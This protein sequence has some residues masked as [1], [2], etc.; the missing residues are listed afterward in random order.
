MFEKFFGFIL[1]SFLIF[2]YSFA[3]EPLRFRKDGTF[4]I[5]QLTDLHYGGYFPEDV[6]SDLAQQTYFET[7]GENTD[8]VVFTGDILAVFCQIPIVAWQ[9]AVY[10]TN[11]YQKNYAVTFGNHDYTEFYLLDKLITMD[12]E[13]EYSYSQKGPENIH[14]V[15]NYYLE[16]LG[17]DSNETQ[18]ILYFFDTGDSDCEGVLG[19]GCVFHN[20]IEWYKNISNYLKEKNN[21]TIPALAF[22]HIPLPEY[23]DVW[24]NNICYGFKEETTCCWSQ[25]TGLYQ[26]F[27]EQ[28]DVYG[29]FVGHDHKNDF[30]GNYNGIYLAYG[31]KSGFGCYEPEL[32]TV[33]GTRII[34]VQEN[35]REIESWIRN[36]NGIKEIQKIHYPDEKDTQNYC[37]EHNPNPIPSSNGSKIHISSFFLFSFSF[38][39]FSFF[40]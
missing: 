4:Q 34:K 24:N 18:L 1:F 26:T 12:M 30:I 33:Q 15:S 3:K 20:Q 35:S 17:S 2:Q 31:R 37:L 38:F 32:P 29:V 5:M 16:V 13:Y 10:F 27:L 9:R 36:K 23:L 19:W 8:F 7:E 28:G 39:F 25:N 22:F 6:Q 14:G 11:F 21:R 40:L